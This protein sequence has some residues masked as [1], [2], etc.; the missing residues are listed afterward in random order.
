M[1]PTPTTMRWSIRKAFTGAVRPRLRAN[2]PV[3][4]P[5]SQLPNLQFQL[6]FSHRG[7]GEVFT[8]LTSEERLLPHFEP[9]GAAAVVCGHTHMQ[10]DRRVGATRVVNAGSVGNPHGE[11]GACWLVLGPGVELRR[12]HYDLERAATRIRDTG[13]PQ[14]REFAEGIVRPVAEAEVLALFSGFE[15]QLPRA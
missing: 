4:T 6:S 15:L 3:P 8:R 14:A 5:A 1:L 13:Y 12:T 9:L 2:Y 11:P 10:F 7:S